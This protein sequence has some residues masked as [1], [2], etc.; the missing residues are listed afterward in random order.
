MFFNL[1]R[2]KKR[3]GWMNHQEVNNVAE[4]LGVSAQDVLEME[5]RMGHYDV[6]FDAPVRGGE[7]DEDNTFS[8]SD[9]MEDSRYDPARMVEDEQWE[10]Q[11]QTRFREALARLDERSRDILQRRWLDEDNKTTLQTLAEEYRVSAER[12]RQIEN[13]A[14][15][16]LRKYLEGKLVVA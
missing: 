15:K 1:R 13:S 5:K 9:Y 3:L 12:I 6:A 4:D 2:S 11:S 10:T 7:D 16:K 8:P 14:M